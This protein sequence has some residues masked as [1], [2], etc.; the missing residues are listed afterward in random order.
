MVVGKSADMTGKSE[1]DRSERIF[2][3]HSHRRYIH[4]W[5]SEEA[6]GDGTRRNVGVYVE[7]GCGGLWVEKGKGLLS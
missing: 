2:E 3:W 7:G 4:D 5:I 6:I 1:L